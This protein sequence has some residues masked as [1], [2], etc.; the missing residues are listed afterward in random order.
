[1]PWVRYFLY[2]G[3]VL[4]ALVFISDS[5]LP[6]N[7]V[8]LKPEADHPAIRIQSDRK[9]PERIVFDTSRPTIV[10]PQSATV[11]ASAPTAVPSELGSKVHGRNSYAALDTL[12]PK[13]AQSV[14]AAKLEKKPQRK[15]RIAKP[16]V[17][18]MMVAQQ[19]Q[20][21]FGFFGN[22]TW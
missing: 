1:M 7:A 11:T 18:P 16:R 17:Q 3:G 5:L 20:F 22:N 6:K 9:W 13:Q 21:A 12:D 15:R 19:P 8:E 10:P 2:V 4:L 14:D